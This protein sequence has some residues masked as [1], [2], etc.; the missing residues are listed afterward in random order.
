M[1]DDG[2]QSAGNFY[3]YI[4]YIYIQPKTFGLANCMAYIEKHIIHLPSMMCLECD[5]Y[6]C[7]VFTCSETCLVLLVPDV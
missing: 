7:C 3:I 4:Y 6:V 2:M 5:V 1:I